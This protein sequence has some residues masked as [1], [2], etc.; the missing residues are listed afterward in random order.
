MQVT[1]HTGDWTR[2]DEHLQSC[3]YASP[4][5]R[6]CELLARGVSGPGVRR[7]DAESAKAWP[8]KLVGMEE[9]PAKGSNQED[10]VMTQVG[11]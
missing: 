6:V 1:S 2:I 7:G 5:E 4:V 10:G 3:A 8:D 9:S 11:V